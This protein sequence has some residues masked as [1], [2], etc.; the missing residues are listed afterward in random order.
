MKGDTVR[1]PLACLSACCSDSGLRLSLE[2]EEKNF[3]VG[4]GLCLFNG[5]ILWPH[6]KTHGL[7][8]K[9]A[10]AFGFAFPFSFGLGLGLGFFLTSPLGLALA[11]EVDGEELLGKEGFLPLLD[12]E[13]DESCLGLLQSETECL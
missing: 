13:V 4:Y 8:R 3:C 5:L 1:A 11:A 7:R 10:D 12:N 9:D 6:E 2:S